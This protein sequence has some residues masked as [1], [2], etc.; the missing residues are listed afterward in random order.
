MS[1]RTYRHALTGR[2]L[3]VSEKSRTFRL[4]EA[5]DNW[6]EVKEVGDADRKPNRRRS[7]PRKAADD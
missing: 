5:D 4:V 2:E 3:C 7:S 1:V 6:S